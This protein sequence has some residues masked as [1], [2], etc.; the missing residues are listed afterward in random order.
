MNDPDTT[1]RVQVSYLEIY[2]ERVR[3]LLRDKNQNQSQLNLKVREHPKDG[4]YVQGILWSN[5][6]PYNPDL[7]WSYSISDVVF[8]YT[9]YTAEYLCLNFKI[10]F[11]QHAL[12]ITLPKM[13]EYMVIK[14]EILVIITYLFFI[15]RKTNKVLNMLAQKY[16]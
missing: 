16:G 9:I 12:E 15:H 11:F 5:Y 2:N 13:S 6:W 8:N 4:P 1:Y 7:R 14:L 3:D 10:V